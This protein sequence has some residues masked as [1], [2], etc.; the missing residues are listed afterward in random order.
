[1][2]RNSRFSIIVP[3][4]N[5]EQ[6][7]R[8]TIFETHNVFTRLG[9]DFEIIVV[10]DG[11]TDYTGN[12]A[13]K[14]AE[15][16]SNVTII[17]LKQ[18]YGKGYAIR[19]GVTKAGGDYIVFMDADL[20][21]HPDQMNR[22]M[23][24]FRTDQYDVA[25]GSKR[26]PESEVNYP[27]SRK[28][29]SVVYYWIVRAF[30]GLRVKDTQAG[31]KVYKREVLLSI[32]PRLLVK[33]FAF[34]LEMLVASHRLGYRIV[35]FPIK[36]TFTRKFGR[37]TLRDCW[38]TGIDTLA[39]FYRNNLL[40]FY[41][42]PSQT[43]TKTPKVSIVI[44]VKEPNGN[45]KLCIDACLD[46][47]YENFE[48]I[49]IPDAASSVLDLVYQDNDKILILPSGPVNPSVKRNMGA[50]K[51]S[52]EILAFLDDD[53]F[54]HPDWMSTAVSQFGNENIAAVGGPGITPAG[55]PLAERISG[56]VFASPLVSGHYRY[57][58][59]PHRFQ[60]VEDYPSCNLFVLKNIFDDIGGFSSQ[61][62]P[63]EDTL[64]CRDI[65]YKKEKKIVYDPHVVVE[66]KR[67]PIILKHLRQV[68]R[69]ALHRGYFVK[70]WPENSLRPAYFAPSGLVVFLAS[71]L[72]FLAI[73]G[74]KEIYYGLLGLYLAICFL[75]SINVG[76][77][78]ET[79]LEFM[80]TIA[81]HITY[82]FFFIIGLARPKLTT[83][84][85]IRAHTYTDLLETAEN[86]SG[87][88]STT[89]KEEI[90]TTLLQQLRN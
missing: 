22:V 71:G 6:S 43:N 44:A 46:Q 31:F 69:Y 33:K 58:Y 85:T 12:I 2:T 13:E 75:F 72:F 29:I 11:S 78:L 84:K 88:R 26:H 16:F 18:N 55:S 89:S 38:Y 53:A 70:R 36:V 21:I 23:K 74:V 49:V 35:E 79:C 64:L 40:D 1:M 67:R 30:F 32:L 5:E 83:H 59:V 7:I 65:I 56:F 37:I 34:D 8:N 77:I 90:A 47:D 27:R 17:N 15:Q 48:I 4:Y 10:N 39:I 24:M 25:I 80:G 51:A 66:H 9:Y 57:R 3:A 87:I 60:E 20:D 63:G 54:P 41:S 50:A 42:Y 76:G 61:H 14:T 19:K 68:S 86:S 73:P 28:I 81:T 45:L 52:G 62:W 82:G